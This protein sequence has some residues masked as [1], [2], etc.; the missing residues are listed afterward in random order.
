MYDRVS[1]RIAIPDYQALML[2]TLKALTWGTETKISDV[3]KQ[4]IN[5][6]GLTSEESQ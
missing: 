6:E 4:V 3:R 2:P 5:A 1:R